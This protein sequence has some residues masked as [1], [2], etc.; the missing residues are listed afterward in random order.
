MVLGLK[1]P[2]EGRLRFKGDL[3]LCGLQAEDPREA[4]ETEEPRP[5]SLG[6]VESQGESSVLSERSE[7]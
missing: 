2:F 1:G 5:C 6:V 4:E 3:S 7:R